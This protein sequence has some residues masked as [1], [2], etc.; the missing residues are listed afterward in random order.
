MID[1]GKIAVLLQVLGAG[2]AVV[3]SL[4]AIYR[5]TYVYDGKGPGQAMTSTLWIVTSEP[6][7]VPERDAIYAMGWPLVFA[8]ALL[9][10]AAVLTLRG[11]TAFVGRVAA[12][13]AAGALGGIVLAYWMQILHEMEIMSGWPAQGGPKVAVDLLGGVYLLAAGAVVGLVGAALGQR[14]QEVPQEEEPEEEVVVHQLDSDDDTPPFGIAITDEQ[15]EA[16]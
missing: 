3:G 14:K 5:T 15:Q 10:V 1:R 13:G 2:L 9:V 7:D 16:R 6:P 11:R 8:A 12:M 4:Q